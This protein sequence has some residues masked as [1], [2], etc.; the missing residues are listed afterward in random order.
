MKFYKCNVCGQ[1]VASVK[2]TGAPMTCCNEELKVIVPH[3]V[4][5]EG[6]EKHI[7]IIKK[8]NGKVVISVG[9]I[10]HPSTEEHFIEWIAI[11]TNKGN[12]RKMLKPGDEPKVTFQVAKDEHLL[13]V[14]VYCN[15]HS[16]WRKHVRSEAPDPDWATDY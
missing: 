8:G 9:S 13:D 10:P 16:L 15:L 6:N 12:Q 2:D 7:P 5:F 3:T 14:Y 4:D 1:I 11:V